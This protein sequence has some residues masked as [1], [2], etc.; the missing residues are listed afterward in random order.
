MSWEG[1]VVGRGLWGRWAAETVRCHGRWCGAELLMGVG[2]QV[3]WGD[4][5]LPV[6][7]LRS[8]GRGAVPG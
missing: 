6:V 2:V 5:H 4:P 3:S 8:R 1:W 7:G